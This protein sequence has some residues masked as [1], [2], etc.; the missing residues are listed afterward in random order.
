[1]RRNHPKI[2]QEYRE[3]QARIEELKRILA[4][5]IVLIN[6]IRRELMETRSAYPSPRRTEIVEDYADLT[7][8]DLIPEEQVVIT[9]T[10]NGYIKRTALDIY[11]SQKRGGKGRRGM[12]TRATR[13]RRALR[14]SSSS[15][16]VRYLTPLP[17]ATWQS[18]T[19]CTICRNSPG[20]RLKWWS[21]PGRERS[22]VKCFSMSAAPRATAATGAVRPVL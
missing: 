3:I 4:D 11:R 6:V 15:A 8:E 16:A 21:G 17:R 9:A 14:Y 1:M 10:R 18:R 5:E 22:R 12:A 2:I 19:A 13:L 20:S 7:I